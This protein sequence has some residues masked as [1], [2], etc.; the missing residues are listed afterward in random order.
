MQ[1]KKLC[2]PDD[3]MSNDYKEERTF[4]WW[5][6]LGEDKCLYQGD[7]DKNGKPDGKG[8]MLEP[9][10]GIDIGYWKLGNRHGHFLSIDEDGQFENCTFRNGSRFKA[11]CE[12]DHELRVI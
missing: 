5:T 7:V 2:F 8:I 11:E 10:G 3:D 9:S 4:K 12:K 6:E 1:K